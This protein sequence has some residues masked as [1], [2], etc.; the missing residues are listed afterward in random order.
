MRIADRRPDD[1]SAAGRQSASLV[2]RAPAVV[3]ALAVMAALVVMMALAACG[4]GK[5]SS[6]SHTRAT[7][8]ATTPTTGATSTTPALSP[9]VPTF[10]YTAIN[11]LNGQEPS[12][13]TIYDLRRSGPF[14]TLDFAVK[15]EVASGAGCSPG[16]DF[17]GNANTPSYTPDGVSLVDPVNDLQYTPVT[18]SQGAFD[19][20]RLPSTLYKSDPAQLAWVTFKAPPA[21]VKSID[22]LFPDGGPQISNLA[23]SDGGAAP[24]PAQ[25]GPGTTAALP[26]KFSEPAGA[27]SIAGLHLPVVALSL[28]VGG[29]T[30]S[31]SQSGAHSKVTLAADVLFR[32]DKSS[33]TPRARSLTNAVARRVRANATGVVAVDGYTD[34]IGSD[35]VNIPLSQARAGSV[36]AALRTVTGPSIRYRTAGHGSQDPVA[37]NTKSDGSDNP[38]GRALNRRV[39]ISYR[40]KVRQPPQA[41]PQTPASSAPAAAGPRTITY[42][43]VGPSGTSTYTIAG[44]QLYRVGNLVALRFSARCQ[45]SSNRNG[46]DGGYDFA[47]SINNVPPLAA[48]QIPNAALDADVDRASG[49]YLSDPSS[50][51]IYNP[52]S[53]SG[54]SLSVGTNPM[55]FG[56]NPY[57]MWVYFAAPP[58]DVSSIDVVMPEGADRI[59][60]MPI[61]L[62]APPG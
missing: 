53:A 6:T 23:I 52:V 51:L 30:G 2:S 13:V 19:G 62:T 61:A 46:C 42:H 5:H 49:L 9:A 27:T 59:T 56:T 12:H 47:G 45:G 31:D 18:D 43:A 26:S 48:N 32:F 25:V 8:H 15:C 24:T 41:P 58:R 35:A 22:V 38:P 36:A 10:T 7:T 11:T 3:V 40:V 60:G 17:S 21:S 54:R 20:S 50:G 55:T 57:P 44:E 16:F 34:S 1:S 14:V 4:G 28:S 37:P 29:R 39:T 33:L